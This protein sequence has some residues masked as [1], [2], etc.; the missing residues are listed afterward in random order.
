MH[1]LLY[2]GVVV[3]HTGVVEHAGVVVYAGVVEHAGVAVHAC[4]VE[5]ACI[6]HVTG[7]ASQLHQL[8]IPRVCNFLAVLNSIQF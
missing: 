6:Y 3:V 4:L 2:T 1:V 8:P 5:H 7:R